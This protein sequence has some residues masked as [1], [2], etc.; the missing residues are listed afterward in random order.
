MLDRI[1]ATSRTATRWKLLVLAEKRQSSQST[2]MNRC[3]GRQR[4]CGRIRPSPAWSRRY[5]PRARSF[6]PVCSWLCPNSSA[7]SSQEGGRPICWFQE[8]EAAA[9]PQVAEGVC[10]TAGGHI[11]RSA[12]TSTIKLR[13]GIDAPSA[14]LSMPR[15]AALS[16]LRDAAFKIM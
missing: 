15:S 7:V 16:D 5:K 8:P 3:L 9:P 13:R 2:V 14:W 4:V 1:A 10:P 12:S 11:R 6:A